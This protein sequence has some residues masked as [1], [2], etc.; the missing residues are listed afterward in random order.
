MD[1]SRF[2][3]RWLAGPRD[4]GDLMRLFVYFTGDHMPTRDQPSEDNLH[5]CPDH[6]S[7]EM[8]RR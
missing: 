3:C 8:C 5:S 1:L 2:W 7:G 4:D 6:N